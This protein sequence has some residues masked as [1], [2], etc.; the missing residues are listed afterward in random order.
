LDSRD[1]IDTAWAAGA[2]AYPTLA[3]SAEL[4]ERFATARID[5]WRGNLERAADLYLACACAEG[6]EGAAVV[7]LDTHGDRIATYLGRI[8]SCQDH[9]EEVRQRVLVRC[10]IGDETR[11]PA[12]TSY[13]GRGSLEGWVR[14]T[15]VREGLALARDG[16]RH[17]ELAESALERPG[18]VDRTWLVARYREPVQE[19]FTV[20]STSLPREH[21]ALLRL[22]YVHG[23]TT[24][25]LARMYR[26]SRSTLVRRLAEARD[27]LVARLAGELEGKAGIAAAD[28]TDV[29]RLLKGQIDLRLSSLLRETAV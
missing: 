28:C 21:R 9:I 3:V 2:A 25:E 13:S 11:P 10:L 29:L 19:A 18:S 20:A 22:H 7:F 17:V 15:A 23:L 26:I 16:A 4:F 6:I 1:L 5:A 27:G 14:A 12:I 8:V 24:N